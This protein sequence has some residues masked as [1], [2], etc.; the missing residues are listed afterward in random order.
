V[1]RILFLGEEGEESY[2]KEV[3]REQLAMGWSGLTR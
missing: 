1:S 3:L 2:A